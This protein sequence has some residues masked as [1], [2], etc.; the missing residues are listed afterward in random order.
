MPKRTSYDVALL[1]DQVSV[2]LVL[3]P[4]ALFAGEG[5]PGVPGGPGLLT[6]LTVTLSNV[7]VLAV[8]AW[9]QTMSPASMFDVERLVEPIVVQ[10][11]PSD[12]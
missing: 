10:E 11:L 4:V 7:D 8:L 5:E 1:A 12:E 9:L 6:P 2:W 3:T